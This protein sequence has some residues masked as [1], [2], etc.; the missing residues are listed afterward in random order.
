M[1]M[2]EFIDQ[3]RERRLK[4]YEASR[5][6]IGEHFGIEEVVLAG[7]YG[8]RSILE[9]VQNGADAI[10]EAHEAG[11]D[12][13]EP[14]R[15][16]VVLDG[17]CLYVANTGEPFS[18]EGIEALLRSHS[19][20]KRG[21]QI[22]RFGLG[23]KSLLR[24]GGKIEIVSA[25][26]SFFMDPVRCRTELC[27][28]FNVQHAPGLRLAWSLDPTR[29]T[30]LRERFPWATT[31]VCAE[32][33]NSDFREHL[34]S[35]TQKFP[36]EFLLFLPVCLQLTLDSGDGLVREL[37]RESDE[38]HVILRE[39]DEASQWRV[40]E[41][42]VSITDQG[43]KNDAMRVHARDA[44][45]L[46]WAMPIDGRR[47]EA[48]RFWAFFPTQTPTY[49]P[50]ILNAPWKLNSDRNAIIPGEWNSALMREAADLVAQTLPSLASSRDPGSV[51]DA[52]PRQLERKDDDASPLVEALWTRMEV[53]AVIPDALGQLRPAR[54]L[55]RHP[56]EKAEL[57]RQWQTIAQEKQRGEIVH[58]SCLEGQRGSRLNALA[59][60]L[61]QKGT[62]DESGPRL[63]P[64]DPAWWFAAVATTEQEQTLR[65]LELAEAY[66]GVSIPYEWNR[67]RS[68]IA[69]IPTDHGRLASAEEAVFA[70]E[71]TPVPDG[72]HPV[73]KWLCEHAEAKRI[74][75][76]VLKVKPLD[77]GVWHEVLL[78]ALHGQQHPPQETHRWCAFWALFRSA[79]ENVR[80]AFVSQNASGF[81]V[82]RR[83]GYWVSADDVLCPGWLVEAGDTSSNQNLLVDEVFH[84]SDSDLLRRLGVRDRPEGEVSVST[85]GDLDQWMNYWREQY[86]Q[87]HDNKADRNYLKP[88][89]LQMPRGWHFLTKLT[90]MAKARLT[91]HLLG[92]LEREQHPTI[93]Q[94]GH[95]T[96]NKYPTTM[97]IPHPL[98]LLLR[99][100]GA[101]AIGDQVV[102]LA[103]L[104]ARRD[105]PALP[106]L[107]DWQRLQP[108]LDRLAE[109]LPQHKE[110]P[111]NKLESLWVAMVAMLVTP[112]MLQSDG[113]QDLWS[114]AAHD[115][116]VPSSL[117]T[118]E[119][120][121]PLAR[122]FVT[123]SVNLARRARTLGHVVVTLDAQAVE[124]WLTKGAQDLSVQIRTNWEVGDGQEALLLEA[125]PEMNVVVR[126]EVRDTA[127]CQSV[128]NLRL[129]VSGEPVPTE[130][131][132]YGNTLLMDTDQLALLSR[133]EKLQHLLAEM[134]SAGWLKHDA[135]E[136][137]RKLG[138]AEV[139]RLRAEVAAGRTLVDRLL[140][141]V[142][143]REEPL[144]SALVRTVPL[145]LLDSVPV[146]QLAEL[147]LAQ[148]G[149]AT[150]TELRETLERE[151][152]N[153]P[154]RWNTVEA[155]A[156]AASIGFPEEFAASAE[157]RREAEELI[158]GPIE[159]PPLHDFQ[160]EVLAGIRELYARGSTRRRAV[161][162]LPTGAGKTRVTVQAAVELVLA[163]RSSPR[164]VLWV[165]QTD[166][167]CEQAVQAF[168][169]V[170]HNLGETDTDLRII[171][172]WGGNPN[173]S[174]PESHKPVAVVASI[175][176]LNSRMDA[177]QLTWL[178]KPGL[179]VIDECHHAIT[180][181]Y[182]N[183]LRFIDA[184]APRPGDPPQDEPPIFG[185]SATPFRTDDE[186][187]QRL[188]RRFD[189]QWLPANQEDLHRRLRAQGVLA[190]V[191]H[192]A[193]DSGIGLSRE[194]IERLSRL[195][196]P[197]QGIDFE[198]LLETINQRLG[199]NKQR[200]ERLLEHIARAEQRSILFFAN[201]VQHANEM[202]ARLN[203]QGIKAAAVNGETPAAARRNFL[204]R[205][206]L[207]E[208]RVL[209]NHSVLSTGF[210]APKVDLVL[211]SRAVF[212]PVRYMQMVGRGLRG[213]KNGGKQRC[214]IVTVLDNLDRFKYRH[215][216]HYCSKNFLS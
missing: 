163:K 137:L 78:R 30:A 92:A 14:P 42:L 109:A 179:V 9:L 211:I 142:G 196:E 197:W 111:A 216:Y 10:L 3:A 79:P 122:V 44:V 99:T 106:R 167:L 214:R 89:G 11:T 158:S 144:R 76:E 36:A 6:D 162:S 87:K 70:P 101:W 177:E 95:T 118:A 192:E 83:D 127:R 17:S 37:R 16:D 7:G 183:L 108:M 199:G 194:E 186:E 48:G 49:L 98:P 155:R 204:N 8:Y 91:R 65:V 34:Q 117:P 191:E 110:V 88:K 181:S 193:L 140:L 13:G 131:L 116:V 134:A 188:A 25:E 71:G 53:D 40:T 45:P 175:Q 168:R 51:L 43:A 203:L 104:V 19:S 154:V 21:N 100:H 35:E 212:S 152:L 1:N 206:Q 205:F 112:D 29:S 213:E 80:E 208:I 60:R 169:Q 202:A 33:V 148:L 176:T 135:G 124:P 72:R 97:E 84:Q 15:V 151:G 27:E 69:I 67:V 56:K 141:A 90:G 81:C 63:Q 136:A 114:G 156:F 59:T 105:Q 50:G 195:K 182:T 201:S 119:G 150:L 103:A 77:D 132:M 138:D 185:L 5:G 139:D 184:E 18:T 28:R 96:P 164:S 125:L 120:E 187:S 128:S 73:A 153:P 38:Q 113:L 62:V 39:Q 190:E 210:D 82:R 165:A 47:E 121:V 160:Q 180:P 123:Q 24:L 23:F 166:E 215:P 159:L 46:A 157:A 207:G 26:A 149:P 20:P 93:V 146:R 31:V 143:Q 198:N 57:A 172:L 75:A 170:W 4:A 129:L 133:A 115:G 61:K 52:F 66:H 64:P 85:H 86:K 209:C 94:F 174:A 130:C 55:W 126:P 68:S 161:V 173:P 54:E 171:R 102:D 200:N 147:V 2:K 107:P 145:E 32:I 12:P 58:P 178:R 189:S 41:K 22:G 74:L